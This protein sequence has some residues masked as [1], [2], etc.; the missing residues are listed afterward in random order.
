MKKLVLLAIIAGACL[1]PVC[2]L[3]WVAPRI[4]ALSE[5]IIFPLKPQFLAML[6]AIFT[7]LASVLIFISFHG[8]RLPGISKAAPMMLIS[9][10]Y[11]SM[12]VVLNVCIFT[13][14]FSNLASAAGK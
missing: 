14:I 9:W 8:S 11:Y 12:I 13:L 7:V 5:I 6:Y 2:E 1:I 4:S 3:L 10:L